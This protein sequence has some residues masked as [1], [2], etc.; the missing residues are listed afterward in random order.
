MKT[1]TILTAVLVCVLAFMT[2]QAALY[3]N[4]S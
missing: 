3:R 1:K 2:A 4:S